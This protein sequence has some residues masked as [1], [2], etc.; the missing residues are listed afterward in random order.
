MAGY[1]EWLAQE[2]AEQEAG[3]ERDLE[4]AV[5]DAVTFGPDDHTR[6]TLAEALEA[7]AAYLRQYLTTDPE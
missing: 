4:R 2:Q 3:A 7:A 1:S 5:E 6:V